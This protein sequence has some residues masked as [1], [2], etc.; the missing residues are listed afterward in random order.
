MRQRGAELGFVDHGEAFDAG[1]D[2]EAFEARNSGGG[3]C[4]DVL[5]VVGDDSAPGGPID[6]A[7][8]LRGGALLFECGDSR[9][10]GQAIERH[11]DERGVAAGRRGAGRGLEAFPLGA[12]G[13]VDVNVGIDEAGENAV[14]A[15]VTNGVAV[16]N[17]VAVGYGLDAA[18]GDQHRRGADAFG[19]NDSS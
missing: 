7:F 16:G 8:A 2:E 13:F 11:V 12:A 6:M 3:Q 9:G 18:V 19:E 10:L 5:L 1:V 17:A 15:E 4:S 14:S